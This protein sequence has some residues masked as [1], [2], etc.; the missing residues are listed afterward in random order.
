MIRGI[1][2]CANPECSELS[3][4]ERGQQRRIG[5]LYPQR[6]HQMRLRLPRA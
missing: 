5:K 6:A 3:E 2:A 1:W 4:D